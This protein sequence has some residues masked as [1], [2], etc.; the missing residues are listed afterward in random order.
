LGLGAGCGLLHRGVVHSS[1]TRFNMKSRF[2]DE[3]PEAC[4]KW[5]TPKNQNF[6]RS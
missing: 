5:L 4:L 1:Q 6:G 3:L 2:Y